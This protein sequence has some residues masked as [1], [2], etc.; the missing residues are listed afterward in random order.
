[1][2][3]RTTRSKCTHILLKLFQS[4]ECP[5]LLSLCNSVQLPTI[6]SYR[7]YAIDYL[8]FF[9]WN[10]GSLFSYTFR[11]DSIQSNRSLSL[12]DK[13]PYQVS[14][15]AIRYHSYLRVRSLSSLSLSLSIIR[16]PSCLRVSISS[17]L[18]SADSSCFPTD[19]LITRLF[20]TTLSRI[21]SQSRLL[22]NPALSIHFVSYNLSYHQFNLTKSHAF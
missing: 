11:C 8:S 17:P 19:R 5:L 12:I 2:Y 7:N 1:M 9:T 6:A 18:I 3:W 4:H 16:S 10:S 22:L 13:I 14:Q 21:A 15:T 20:C